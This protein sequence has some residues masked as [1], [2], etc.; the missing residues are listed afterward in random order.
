[1]SAQK[2]ACS[3]DIG[4]GTLHYASIRLL[5]PLLGPGAEQDVVLSNS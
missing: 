5:T 2:T 1:M 3:Y 4:F